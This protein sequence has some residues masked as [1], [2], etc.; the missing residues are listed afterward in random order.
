M[1]VGDIAQRILEFLS[2]RSLLAFR[3]VFT[4]P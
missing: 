4:R 3:T 1:R 2:G